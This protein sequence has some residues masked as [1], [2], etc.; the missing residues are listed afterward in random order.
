MKTPIQ[1][2]KR[3]GSLEPLD[4]DKIN[5]LLQFAC[6]GLKDVSASAIALGMHVKFF[7]GIKT[8]DIHEASIKTAVDLITTETPDYQYVAARLLSY[9][10]RKMV[11]GQYEPV[12]FL[13]HVKKCVKLGVYDKEVFKL[14]TDEEIE[15]LG[16]AINHNYDDNFTYAAMQLFEDKYLIRNRETNQ[17]FETPQMAYMMIAMTL[18][19]RDSKDARREMIV[20]YYKMIATGEK[21][22]ISLPT[23]IA[24][25]V[26]TPT[27]QFS[28]CVVLKAGDSLESINA[29]A[30]TIV[31]YAAKRAGIGIDFSNLRPKF[32][33]I[34]GGE[35][36][37]TGVISFIKYIQGAVKSSSQGGIR[38][39]SASLYFP[40]WHKEIEDLL[41]LKNNKGTEDARARQLDYGVSING[42]FYKKAIAREEYCL[43][44]PNDYP[45]LYQ[46]FFNDQ[47]KYAELYDKYSKSRK[48]KKIDAFELLN[49]L[50]D[51][52]AQTGRIYIFNV[53]TTNRQSAFKSPIYSSNLCLEI[54]LPSQNLTK[55]GTFPTKE[56]KALGIYAGESMEEFRAKFGEI[57]L[58]TLSAI[59]WGNIKKPSDFEKPARLAVRALDNLLDYQD[60]PV[61]AAEIPGR[62]R[63]SLG[64]GIIN[65]AHFLAKNGLKYG[66]PQALELV[67]EYMEAMY[68]YLMKANV[69]LAKE[70]GAC[71]W[72]ADT[73]Y[74]DGEFVWE[75]RA[76]AVDSII[77]HTP[78]LDWESLREDMKTYGVRHSTVIAMMPSETSAVIS[79]ATNGIEPPRAATTIKSNK[80]SVV[81]QLVPNPRLKYDYLWDQPTPDGYLKT[82]AVLQKYTDQ[83]IS[84]N[85]S[86]NPANFDG[87]KVPMSQLLRDLLNAYKYGLKTLYYHNTAVDVKGADEGDCES[88]KI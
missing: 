85:T 76:K 45:D 23:P 75:K 79:N 26:R 67:D 34:R 52:R 44:N 11:Y 72:N 32:A 9:K 10:L 66:E 88:C 68:F 22:I 86:Y 8:S 42:H 65:L 55:L 83:A 14:Y 58:C 33:A 25:G 46:A 3:D 36:T 69:E 63:R 41:V 38:S 13:T 61:I 48:V 20:D 87:G 5:K 53:D 74:S 80:D 29:T 6:T 56:A 7:D 71:D 27:R 59:N 77:P 50:V 19:G 51:E 57:A 81:K 70:R 35:A 39:G 60:Y 28:S 12:D 47:D 18:F 1:V 43:F 73:Y 62:A 17:F 4:F 54:S 30:S 49:R 40:I 16:K 64:V 15:S 78:R 24:G 37:H 21:S 84:A 82:M 2:K 31:E